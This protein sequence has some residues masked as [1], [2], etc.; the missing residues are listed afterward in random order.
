MR[1]NAQLEEW[2]KQ[3]SQETGMPGE[4]KTSDIN[5]YKMLFGKDLQVSIT[6]PEERVVKFEGVIGALPT[7][8]TEEF[9]TYAAFANLFGEG[10][11]DSVISLDNEGK[12]LYLSR[13]IPIAI[14]YGRF[15]E[16]VEMFVNYLEMW[17]KKRLDASR[18][19]ASYQ[20]GI[21]QPLA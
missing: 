3:L 10:T 9:V 15:K 17:Q 4:L 14:N 16:D 6:M 19:E 18:K 11:G 1:I 2:I 8:K 20:N 7:V 13:Q 12:L 5:V 21:L